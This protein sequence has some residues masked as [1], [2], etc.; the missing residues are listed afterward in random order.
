[1]NFSWISHAIDNLTTQHSAIFLGE[2]HLWLHN[3]GIAVLIVY[4]LKW[5]LVSVSGH[6]GYDLPG[7][8]AFLMM[9]AVASFMLTFYDQPLPFSNS[10]FARTLPNTADE[11]STMIN[12][13]MLSL[14]GGKLKTVTDNMED[15]PSIVV[16]SQAFITW[17]EAMAIM[18]ILQAVMMGV[19]IIGYMGVGV[20]I[21]M[22]SLTIPFFVWPRMSWVFWN[23]LQA[24]LEFSFWRVISTAIVYVWATAWA[25]FI[26]QSIHGD[27]TLAHFAELMPYMLAM[28]LGVIWSVFFLPSRLTGDMFKGT[29]TAGA[30]FVG[31]I[32]LA[33]R[34]AV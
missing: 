34:A 25:E 2:A 3:I 23:W 21:L 18:D 16:N 6:G 14:V 12:N 13:H 5:T 24:L 17:L 32:A 15:A 29:A 28:L 4:A 7:L 8:V 9:F 31:G 27:Y 26:D 19:L 10:S 22:G 30:N 1:L 11:L 20:L 33:V